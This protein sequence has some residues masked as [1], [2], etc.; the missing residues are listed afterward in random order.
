[1]SDKA[2][3]RIWNQSF[4]ISVFILITKHYEKHCFDCKKIVGKGKKC[5]NKKNLNC[6]VWFILKIR[7]NKND[8]KL[9]KINQFQGTYF[10]FSSYFI[11]SCMYIY[12]NILKVIFYKVLKPFS[13]EKLNSWRLRKRHVRNRNGLA[14]LGD[15]LR[16]E[17]ITH[18]NTR[19]RWKYGEL[20]FHLFSANRVYNLL[21]LLPLAPFSQ[22]ET[23]TFQFGHSGLHKI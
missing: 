4:K 20:L 22:P 1:M 14:V 2:L 16:A 6:F 15:E 9:K 19:W 18:Q 17:Y 23:Q 7:Y 5:K 12:S 11:T 10:L 8:L 13:S 3:I 21:D